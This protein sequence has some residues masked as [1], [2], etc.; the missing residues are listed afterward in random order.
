MDTIK[1]A[2]ILDRENAEVGQ[3]PAHR[4]A[5]R[6]PVPIKAGPE[7]SVEAIEEFRQVVEEALRR[8]RQA[9]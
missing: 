4:P 7:L 9:H 2:S 5:Q 6:I 8:Y 1:V 3:V